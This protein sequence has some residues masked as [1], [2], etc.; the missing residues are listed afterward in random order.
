MLTFTK[1]YLHNLNEGMHTLKIEERRRIVA[2]LLAQSMNE[3]EIA[4]R[5]DQLDSFKSNSKLQCKK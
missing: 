1:D 3:T 2:S 5:H 4:N